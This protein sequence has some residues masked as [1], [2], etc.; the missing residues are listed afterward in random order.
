M[1]LVVCAVLLVGSPAL[2]AAGG[3]WAYARS[4]IPTGHSLSACPRNAPRGP[5]IPTA[6]VPAELVG[7]WQRVGQRPGCV[8]VVPP[9]SSRA[10]V[11]WQPGRGEK[12]SGLFGPVPGGQ[13]VAI[14]SLRHGAQ[15]VTIVQTDGTVRWRVPGHAL[16]FM[17]QGELVIER[18]AG[19]FIVTPRGRATILV[20]RSAIIAALGFQPDRLTGSLAAKRSRSATTASRSLAT[21][22]RP[23]RR[24][25]EVQ[26][27]SPV[28]VAP[29]PPQPGG[30]PPASCQT[31]R[32]GIGSALI[33]SWPRDPHRTGCSAGLSRRGPALLL[34][35]RLPGGAHAGA[36]G[37]PS[38]RIP[39]AAF[40]VI[41]L[42][43]YESWMTGTLVYPEAF[44]E[45]DA[46]GLRDDPDA[47]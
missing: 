37:K 9:G 15:Y 33:S 28:A 38:L 19:L 35:A 10:V 46:V 45:C 18:R 2:I 8:S 16:G 21:Q 44:W 5:R 24:G 41:T 40:Q 25:S 12:G 17:R 23:A 13:A 32:R 27:L 26:V 42:E 39:D 34:P 29:P 43:A 36:F 11:V 7:V 4:Q 1:R 22:T 31:H 20:K 30:P 6:Y 47:I 14:E 3:S